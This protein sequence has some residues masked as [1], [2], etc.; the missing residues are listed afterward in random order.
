MMNFMLFTSTVIIW[1]TTWIAIAWQIGSVDVV[2]SIFYR[3]ALAGVVF[4][5]GLL[6]LGRLK[7]PNQ[8]RF[9]VLGTLSI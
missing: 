8:W 4:L 2:V 1:G 7:L 3:F 5:F 9:V 6:L